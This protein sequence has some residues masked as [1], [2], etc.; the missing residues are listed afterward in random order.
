MV[1]SI[2]IENEQ[3]G[4]TRYVARLGILFDR[5]RAGQLLGTGTASGRRSAPFLVIPVLQTGAQHHS[6]ESRN[7]WL[8]AWNRFRT[9]G[10]AIDYVAP[11]APASILCCSMSSRPG[12]PAVPGGA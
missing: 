5:G 3:I 7:E 9:G 10:S 12:A 1:S 4:P 8:R 2:V 11:A 6:F